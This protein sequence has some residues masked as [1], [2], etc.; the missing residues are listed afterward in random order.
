MTDW[1]ANT[2]QICHRYRKNSPLAIWTDVGKSRY[3]TA[4]TKTSSPPNQLLG[5]FS[6][7]NML[8]TCP[9]EREIKLTCDRQS[10]AT[11]AHRRDRCNLTDVQHPMSKKIW[12][13]AILMVILI[14]PSFILIFTGGIWRRESSDRFW[15]S[16]WLFLRHLWRPCHRPPHPHHWQQFH[17]VLH[18][19]EAVGGGRR[20]RD[21]KEIQKLDHS[22]A[23]WRKRTSVGKGTLKYISLWHILKLFYQFISYI[24]NLSQWHH[25]IKIVS[26][27]TSQAPRTP[28]LLWPKWVGEP[29]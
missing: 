1:R 25:I 6:H 22:S 11:F 4:W 10:H 17:Q 20:R 5:R 16:S 2:R 14:S 27:K 23:W 8:Q 18:A 3:W 7:L 26:I 12:H 19:A 15:E 29:D 28:T 9:I 24:Q 13:P 21:E